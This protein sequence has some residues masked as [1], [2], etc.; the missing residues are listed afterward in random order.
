MP[1]FA[2]SHSPGGDDPQGDGEHQQYCARADSHKGFHDKARV[3]VYLVERTDAARWSVGKEFAVQQHHPR[4][5]VQTKK[6]GNRQ[7]DIHISVRF[8]WRIGKGQARRPRE[9]VVARDGVYGAHQDLQ[10]YEEDAFV[11]HGYPPIVC[12]VVHHK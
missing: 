3:E 5:E 2:R 6:H 1:P 11:G 4:D 8:G 9:S 12:G 10:A 7:D